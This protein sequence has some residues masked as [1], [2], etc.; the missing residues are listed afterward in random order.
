MAAG[1]DPGPGI[2]VPQQQHRSFRLQMI[3]GA[4]GAAVHQQA[5]LALAL[6]RGG[7]FRGGIRGPGGGQSQCGGCHQGARAAA[8]HGDQR[9]APWLKDAEQL[10][11]LAGVQGPGAALQGQWTPHLGPA[12]Q[13]IADL[14]KRSHRI[15]AGGKAQA[16][17]G[18]SLRRR[19]QF[20]GH[21]GAPDRRETRET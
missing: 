14:I 8:L 13:A 21:G 1:A 15:L 17:G 18:G 11:Q 4:Q 19:D 3:A 5:R 7:G 12:R 10:P 6:D 20:G 16:V 9:E 2:E